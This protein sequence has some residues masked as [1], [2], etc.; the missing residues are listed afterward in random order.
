MTY[1]SP[2][3]NRYSPA[4]L[5]AD[6]QQK[7]S[8]PI[9]VMELLQLASQRASSQYSTRSESSRAS[10][11]E[12]ASIAGRTPSYLGKRFS[13][14]IGVSFRSLSAATRDHLVREL[15][16]SSDLRIKEIAGLT[17]YTTVSDFCHS[18]RRRHGTTPTEYR[19]SRGGAALAKPAPL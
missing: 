13:R 12:M 17:G 3:I 8:R 2:T 9:G 11:K 18:F 14:D 19:R 1:S 7:R 15:L 16:E 5:P 6:P 10:L 4:L